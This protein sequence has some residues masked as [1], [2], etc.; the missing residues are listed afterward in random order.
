MFPFL[1]K[2]VDSTLEP[3]YLVG[4]QRLEKITVYPSTEDQILTASDGY[5]GFSEVDMPEVTSSIDSN[6][7]PEN[8]RKHTSILGVWGDFEPGGD[9]TIIYG[10]RVNTNNVAGQDVVTYL[11]DAV[12]MTPASMG[13][14]SFDYGSWENAFFMPRPCMVDHTTLEVKYY[15]DPN[16]YSKKLDGTPSEYNDVNSGA[17][18]M[19]E[20]PKIW[21]KFVQNGASGSGEF[22]CSNKQVDD[23]YHCWCNINSLAQEIDHFYMSAYYGGFIIVNEESF[24]WRS[25][26]GCSLQTLSADTY[27]RTATYEVGDI[28]CNGCNRRCITAVEEP[29]VFDPSKWE[30]LPT[31][32]GYAN[33]QT[34]GI[35][36]S[37]GESPWMVTPLSDLMLLLGLLILISKS[38]DLQS[39]F[40]R[41]ICSGGQA[42]AT[43]YVTGAL[44]DKGL[45]WG[46]T[47]SDSEPVKVFGIENFWGCINHYIVGIN[48]STSAN[49]SYKYKSTKGLSDL[50]FTDR[51][52]P[53]GGGY[54]EVTTPITSTSSPSNYIT[55]MIFGEFG[56]LPIETD[57]EANSLWKATFTYGE[58]CLCFGGTASD[59]DG[60]GLTFDF[61]N[62][63]YSHTWEYGWAF[64]FKPYL[65]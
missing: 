17:S 32:T 28:V 37:Y 54:V 41:G 19:V 59:G 26:S 30:I 24:S 25:L 44:D 57:I 61:S 12:G 8:I 6:I 31:Y 13:A 23:T 18:V 27:D 29:E 20:F 58:D 65:T 5:S 49:I 64:S 2:G 1:N 53:S 56:M 9:E 21:Y 38:L 45:F 7:V 47:S 50:S 15:L 55:T 42:A 46:S 52:N 33:V 62:T 43:S 10:F 34:G 40:G 4:E 22:Y 11:Q 36:E 39:S 35:T 16:D 63:L 3:A 14:S 51:F 48:G 60:C